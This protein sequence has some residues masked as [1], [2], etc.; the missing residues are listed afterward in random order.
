MLALNLVG[1]ALFVIGCM[2]MF[3][4]CIMTVPKPL[5]WVGWG[6]SLALLGFFLIRA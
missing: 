5:R 3:W 1:V 2:A 6:I 4:P